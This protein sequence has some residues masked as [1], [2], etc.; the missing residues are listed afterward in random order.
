MTDTP[1]S[2]TLLGGG[3]GEYMKVPDHHG[4][5]SVAEALRAGGVETLFFLPGG[6]VAPVV[7]GCREVGIR[8]LSTRHESAAVFMAEG[9]ARCT[10]RTGVAAITAGPGFTNG[11]TGIANSQSTGIPTVVLG[12]R[13][14]LSLRGMGAVQD[15]DQES[16]ARVVAKWARTAT[17]PESLGPLVREALGVARTGRPLSLIHI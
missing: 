11:V 17:T 15:C 5:V 8:L 1:G 6:H 10:G 3:A 16:V 9:W 4:G 2:E 13:T 14:P 12:G 7:N